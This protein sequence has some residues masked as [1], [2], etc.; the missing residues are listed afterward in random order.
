MEEKRKEVK[1]EKK[2]ISFFNIFS[3]VLIALLT[4]AVIVELAL[5]IH[6]DQEIDRMEEEI[7]NIPSISQTTNLEFDDFK[8]DI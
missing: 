7:S 5:I 3:Y 4:V 8:Y 2:K 6:Y 1:E